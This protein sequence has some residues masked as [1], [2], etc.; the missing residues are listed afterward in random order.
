MLQVS[1]SKFIQLSNSEKNENISS[2]DKVDS[3][4][5]SF[6]FGPPYIDA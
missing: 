5:M 2:I 6:F 1:C 3:N 4:A